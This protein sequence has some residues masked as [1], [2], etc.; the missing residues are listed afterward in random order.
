MSFPGVVLQAVTGGRSEIVCGENIF[1]YSYVSKGTGMERNNER[2]L[3][4]VRIAT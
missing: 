1:A 4:C 3:I 2:S